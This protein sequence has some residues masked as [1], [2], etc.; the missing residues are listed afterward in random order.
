M[1]VLVIG[2]GGRE[3]ALAWKIKQSPLL[4][5]LF[6]HPSH[7]CSKWMG[8]PLCLEQKD[9]TDGE[10]A[11]AAVAAKIDLVV[12]GPEGPLANGL[13]DRLRN[14]GICVF[15]PGREGAKL[16]SSKAFA[17]E[18]MERAHVPT[19]RYQLC[20]GREPTMEC[21]RGWLKKSGGVVLK[22]SGLAGGKG[23]FVCTQS[24]Q[25]VEAAEHLF[26]GEMANAAAQVVVEELMVGR[27]SSFFVLLDTEN[28]VSTYQVI[29]SAVDYKRLK[30]GN[31]GPNT[32]GMGGYAPVPWV[33]DKMDEQVCNTIVEPVVC[34]LKAEGISYRGLL[35]VGLMWTGDG[36]KVVEFNCRFGDPEAE[37]LAV[38][39]VRDWLPMLAAAAGVEGFSL[40]SSSDAKMRATVA[41]VIASGDYP[42]GLPSGGAPVPL[43]AYPIG[44][45]EF[46]DVSGICSYLFGAGVRRVSDG[47]F[48]YGKGRMLVA[49]A[50]GDN[51]AQARHMVHERVARIS[52]LWPEAQWRTDIAAEVL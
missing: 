48:G 20:S 1:R 22:A 42:F 39:D 9:I 15:G 16:E 50:C 7:P 18:F 47:S 3:H 35:Y 46:E 28:Q 43:S 44:S 12:V 21:A 40:D 23:V 6:H 10:L 49:V 25:L 24:A 11:D 26:K 5:E 29:G 4:G 30:T 33:T 13:A 19:A 41:V 34:R 2:S 32:G 51:F 27:E 52:L 14:A 45:G 31:L 8:S 36:P 38:A 17:K 37:I